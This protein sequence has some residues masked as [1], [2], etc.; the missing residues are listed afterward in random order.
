MARYLWAVSLLL[1]PASM[2]AGEQSIAKLRSP[3]G[4]VLVRG[5][6]QELAHAHAV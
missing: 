5:S 1:V 4:T 6:D 3:V 2:H